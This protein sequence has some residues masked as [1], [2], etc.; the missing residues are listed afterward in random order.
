MRGPQLP[1]ISYKLSGIFAKSHYNLKSEY[2]RSLTDIKGYVLSRAVT[3]GRNEVRWNEAVTA[4]Y[5]FFLDIF[6]LK[7]KIL[8]KIL[9]IWNLVQS[10]EELRAPWHLVSSPQ[11]CNNNSTTSG[12]NT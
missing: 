10:F 2:F 3:R 5:S 9:K 11:A 4:S 1:E 7:S 6:S 12:K 8:L